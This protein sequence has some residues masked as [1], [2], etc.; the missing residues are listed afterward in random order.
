MPGMIK[1]FGLERL[2]IEDRL[3]LIEELWDSIAAT[4]DEVPVSEA[5]RQDLQR[6]LDASQADPKVGSTW[7]EV[8]RRLGSKP[9]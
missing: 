3:R 8:R 1:R 9:T 6:R 4:P 7:E 2:S 5:Q